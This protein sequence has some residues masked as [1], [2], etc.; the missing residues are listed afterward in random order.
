MRAAILRLRREHPHGAWICAHLHGGYFM[1]RDESELDHYLRSDE[2][3][4]RHLLQRV[5]RQRRA[6][7]LQSSP[8]L[9][10][11]RR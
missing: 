5:R 6:A 9:E 4:A 11:F 8:Q 10:L 3:R 1:A 2:N 7:G